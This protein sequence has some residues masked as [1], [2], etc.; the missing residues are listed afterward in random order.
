MWAK[1][2][3]TAYGTSVVLRSEPPKKRPSTRATCFLDLANV[4]AAADPAG[5]L[6]IT[7]Y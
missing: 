5:P 1:S 4:V 7:V 6:P 2:S 3:A